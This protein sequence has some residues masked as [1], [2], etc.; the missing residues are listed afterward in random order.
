MTAATPICHDAG[1]RL[2]R[3]RA[4]DPR[5]SSRRHQLRTLG[6]TISPA[7]ET[8]I[9]RG[10]LISAAVHLDPCCCADGVCRT[11]QKSEVRWA[12][13]GALASAFSLS[14]G[15]GAPQ[16]PFRRH[17]INVGAPSRAASP[18]RGEGTQLHSMAEGVDGVV[19]AGCA[20]RVGSPTS[21]VNAKVLDATQGSCAT[22]SYAPARQADANIE[23]RA[24]RR[25]AALISRTKGVLARSRSTRRPVAERLDT[26]GSSRR[27]A[28]AVGI[29][30][31]RGWASRAGRHARSELAALDCALSAIAAARLA[32]PDRRHARRGSISRPLQGGEAPACGRVPRAIRP[33]PSPATLAEG[34]LVRPR[35]PGSGCA[36]SAA[37]RIRPRPS[38]ASSPHSGRGQLG[39]CYH[40]VV[41]RRKITGRC[42]DYYA[43][44]R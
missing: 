13:Q 1:H 22:P 40:S 16:L 34:A 4:G 26:S 33:R 10:H 29:V 25:H 23:E 31:A 15:G 21:S 5:A 8:R 9:R 28:T 30:L 7:G 18:A 24:R 38:S 6:S 37:P 43:S 42:D 41:T 36:P 19:A 39:G 27:S 35:W 17:A 12:H 14:D 32:R 20:E 2:A 44:N 11:G 3:T